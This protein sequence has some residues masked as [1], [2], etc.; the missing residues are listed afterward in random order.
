MLRGG[1]YDLVHTRLSKAGVVGRIAARLAR[2]PAVHTVDDFAFVEASGLRRVVYLGLERAMSRLTQHTMFVSENEHRIAVE[3]RIGAPE[4]HTVIGHGVD[5]ELF[6]PD[7]LDER[8]LAG[9]RLRYGLSDA[10]PVIGG[11]AR[12]VPRKGWETWLSAARGV[13]HEFPDARFL[14]VGGGP[15]EARLRELARELG[16]A[17]QVIFTGFVDDQEEM[18]YFFA[19][20]D[21]FCVLS[22]REGFGMVFAEAGA[23]GKPVIAGDIAPVNEIVRH[24]ETGVL[25]P[26][27]DHDAASEAMRRL[28]RDPA[29]ANAMGQLG[30]RRVRAEFDLSTRHHRVTEVYRRV[31]ARAPRRTPGRKAMSGLGPG[32]AGEHGAAST[33]G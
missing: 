29:Q 9:M 8:R 23:M 14:V 20:M 11:V 2:V 5:L 10:C 28:I 24:D 22:M 21:V 15:Q 16:I 6:D 32:R 12:L 25:V 19:M 30:R 3:H 4:R 31:L 26:V 7:L 17:D 1:E 18:P 33:D 27:R 13:L